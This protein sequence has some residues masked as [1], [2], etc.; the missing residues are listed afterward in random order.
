MLAIFNS[1]L[2]RLEIYTINLHKILTKK[3]D[4]DEILERFEAYLENIGTQ[5]DRVIH[6]GNEVYGNLGKP[7]FLLTNSQIFNI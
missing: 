2:A 5:V 6:S 7:F 3:V 4:H 1:A